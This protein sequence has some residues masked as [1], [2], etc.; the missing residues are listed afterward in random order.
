[1]EKTYPFMAKGLFYMVAVIWLGLTCGIGFPISLVFIYM[2][3]NAKIILTDNEMIYCMLGKTHIP[4][5]SIERLE[6]LQVNGI[7]MA[8]AFE[9]NGANIARARL[10]PLQIHY[11]NGK[12]K[13]LSI[14]KFNYFLD[15]LDTL[16]KKTNLQLIIH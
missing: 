11:N 8:S 10:I 1:M 4:Y 2:A 5:Q 6:I 15:I 13:R 12:K 14:N 16:Q 7:S 9:N 3:K